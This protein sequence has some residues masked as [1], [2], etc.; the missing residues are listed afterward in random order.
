MSRA[1]GFLDD[2][3][4]SPL[5]L[6]VYL[7]I[8]ARN[9]LL[10]P[11]TCAEAIVNGGFESMDGW[12]INA[13]AIPAGYVT[14]PSPAHSGGRSMRSGIDGQAG[15]QYAFSSFQQTVSIP[16]NAVAA[17]LSFWRYRL[18]TNTIDDRQMLRLTD[19]GGTINYPMYDQVNDPTWNRA[20]F[21]LIG[22]TSPVTL[23]FNTI[24][25]ASAGTTAMY[26]DDVSLEICTP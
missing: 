22:Y 18:S 13:S 1:M 6:D 14:V 8:V 16:P 11:P 5:D 17:T 15:D 19:A 10:T 12:T 24:N 9:T 21:D 2:C 7:P 4:A 25:N 3:V 23:Y 20:Q 26:I